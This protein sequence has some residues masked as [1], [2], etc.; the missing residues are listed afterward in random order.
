L[1]IP[2][3]FGDPKGFGVTKRNEI[4]KPPLLL[5]AVLSGDVLIS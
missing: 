3:D 5:L 2:V 1:N 4:S